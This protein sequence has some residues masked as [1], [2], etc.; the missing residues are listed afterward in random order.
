M[1]TLTEMVMQLEG[2]CRAVSVPVIAAL[3][4]V[5]VIGEALSL[6]AMG[7][8]AIVLG[9]VAIAVTAPRLQAPTQA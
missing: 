2:V 7:A 1:R 8:C 4:G 3:G 6:R 9:G 5:W